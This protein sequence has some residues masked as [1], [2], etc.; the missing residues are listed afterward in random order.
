VHCRR[1]LADAE[2]FAAR[3]EEAG[4]SAAVFAADLAD[5]AAVASLIPQVTTRLGEISVLVNNAG[6]YADAPFRSLSLADWNIVMTVNVIAAYRLAQGAIAGMERM[7]WGR[8]INLGATSAYARSHS[9][10]GLAKAALL[11]LTECLA[12]EFAPLVTVNAIVPGQIASARTDTMKTY[13]AAA[14][15]E[16]PLA[17]LV[18]EQEV[19]R[20]AALLCTQ[21]F[22][23]MTGR[24]IVMD[25]G[26]SL[27]RTMRI[28]ISTTNH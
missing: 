20:M 9:V 15:A 12:L 25:G 10:Y 18:T 4:G 23:S 13:K 5:P 26:R 27:P 14:I 3:I 17:R 22:S 1:A 21:D 16:T 28:D 11:H 6:P 19:A 8:I 7:G 2:S 24:S